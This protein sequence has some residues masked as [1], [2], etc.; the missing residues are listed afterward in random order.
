MENE[1]E[2]NYFK[3]SVVVVVALV[4]L[5]AGWHWGGPAYRQHK[6]KRNVAEAQAFLE[7]GDYRN[8]WLCASVAH[9]LNSNSVPA[10]RVLATVAE[11]ARSPV[12]LDLRQQIVELEPRADNQ[13]ALALAGLRF[14]NP[15]FALTQQIL[16]QLPDTATN[17]TAFQSVAAELALRLNRPA[18]AAAH[19]EAALRLEPTNSSFQLNLAVLRLNS[20]NAAVV[21]AAR[22]TLNGFRTDTNLGPTALRSLVTERLLHDDPAAARDY[23]TQLL[24][25]AQS[26]LGD[27]LQ[28]LGI[29]KRLQS[30]D[31][32]A[33]LNA[34]QQ[35]AATNALF[36]AQTAAWMQGNGFMAETV[37]W[38]TNLPASLQAQP[39]VQLA[40]VDYYSSR[41]K[42]TGGK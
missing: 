39:P 18:D 1:G 5:A 9:M 20:T 32:A 15:P 12:A 36:T 6:E 35:D 40:L 34:V 37:N 42:A 21:S 31:L 13:L 3:I 8:A 33:Q 14:Q 19:L 38:L 16:D 25:S 29:L 23:V 7:R 17:L 24:A 41:P 30:P 4:I 11:A 10:A 22:D 26:N 28:Y 2:K 27:R